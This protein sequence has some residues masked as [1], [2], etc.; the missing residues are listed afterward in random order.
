M[1]EKNLQKIQ[2]FMHE[3]KHLLFIVANPMSDEIVISF[4]DTSTFTKF[5]PME[6]PTLNV[7][8]NVLKAGKF[9]RSI[10]EFITGLIKG[11][12]TD[13]KKG[14]QLYKVIGGSLWKIGE[15]EEIGR[16]NLETNNKTQKNVKQK[17]N[18]RK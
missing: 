13:E 4:N 12:G 5:P 11:L 9:E 3:N 7:V 18:K 14:A 1:D 6:N 8:F 10:D 2:E 16:K 15:E 17:N